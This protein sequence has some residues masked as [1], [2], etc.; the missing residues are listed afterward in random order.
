[1]LVAG[2]AVAAPADAGDTPRVGVVTMQPGEIFFE[3]FGHD[4]VVVDDPATGRVTSYNFGFF[5]PTEDDFIA[6]FVRGDMRYRLAA[7]PFKEDLLYYDR[8]GR[9]ASIQWLDLP[10]ARAR[11]VAKALE[12]NARPENAH[13]RYDYFLDNCSTRVRD[14]V[15]FALGGALRR[16]LEGRSRGLTYR[17]EATRLASP[18]PWMWLGFDIGLGPSADRPLSMWEEAFVPMRLADALAGARG[19][20]GA[21]VVGAV[22][23]LLPHR[24]S[25]EPVGS[26]PWWPAWAGVGLA[27][28][29]AA[30]LAARR[31]PRTVVALALPWWTLCAVLGA[32]ML[33][34][35][36]GTGHRFGWQNH[37]LLLFNPLCL[38]L[39][40]GGWAIA[41]GR[42]AGRV[43]GIALV[44]VAACAV[45]ALFVHWLPVMPQRNAHWI[46]LVLPLHLGLAIGLLAPRHAPTAPATQST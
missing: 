35:W 8:T 15:D 44:A 29:I 45:L 34:I 7:L 14:S 19:A 36:F 43:F 6:R 27:F 26:R 46:A 21:P 32:L 10:P 20:D 42:R 2:A 3:R 13:Y 25:P 11:A 9:G 28:G 41:R 40:P 39:L 5:D 23:P 4:A 18:A 31:W 24:I 37:N 16:Q 1:M 17:S 38:L 33:F 30:L 12:V 22:Q